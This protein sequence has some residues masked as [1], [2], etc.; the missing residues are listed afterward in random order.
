MRRHI[1]GNSHLNTFR[2]RF[3]WFFFSVFLN[4]MVIV[5][6]TRAYR[7]KEGFNHLKFPNHSICSM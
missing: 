3:V 1:I 4:R 6:L 7:L 5:G 2:S